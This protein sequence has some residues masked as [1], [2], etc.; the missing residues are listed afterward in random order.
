MKGCGDSQS[1]ESRNRREVAF[2][3]LDA[4]WRGVWIRY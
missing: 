4:D 2:Q 1:H 3:W